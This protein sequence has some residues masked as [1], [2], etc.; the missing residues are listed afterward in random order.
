MSRLGSLKESERNAAMAQMLQQLPYLEALDN[1]IND[2]ISAA[3][4]VPTPSGELYAPEEL[5]DP[6][7]AKIAYWLFCLL[8]F[9][10]FH[11]E[12]CSQAI[13]HLRSCILEKLNVLALLAVSSSLVFPSL[14]INGQP[15]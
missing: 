14:T 15:T 8:P 13:P 10:F 1:D 9:I 2:F 4:F 11:T 5:Y 6:R 3:A 7:Q 12:L